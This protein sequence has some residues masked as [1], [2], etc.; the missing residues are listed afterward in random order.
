[1]VT[2][3]LGFCKWDLPALCLVIAIAVLIVVHNVRY[4]S[5]E[6]AYRHRIDLADDLDGQDS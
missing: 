1:M 6:K 3:S 2:Y 5:K 4:K